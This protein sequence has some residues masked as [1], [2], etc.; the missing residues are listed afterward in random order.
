[1]KPVAS[2]NKIAEK[3][4]RHAIL[5]EVNAGFRS[6]K[7][8]NAK[9][10]HLEYDLPL[11]GQACCDQVLDDFVLGID[12]NAF[13]ACQF[14]EINAMP[15]TV[16]SQFNSVMN[17]A[18]P[19]HALADASFIEQ[20]H[21]SLFE[22]TRAD[23]F[24][25]VVSSSGFQHDGLNTPQM[26]KMREHEPRGTRSHNSDLRSHGSFPRGVERY[27]SYPSKNRFHLLSGEG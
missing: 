1:M 7:I 2:S 19:P 12:R 15:A 27:R 25:N 22:Q 20:I 4:L 13:A 8:V 11:R 9:V 24:F 6:C 10:I 3:L 17:Q 23:T 5:P 14:L 26:Q 21:G 16:E 18:L